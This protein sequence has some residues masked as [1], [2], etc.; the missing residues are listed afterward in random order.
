VARE[1]RGAGWRSRDG[2]GS[3]EPGPAGRVGVDQLRDLPNGCRHVPLIGPSPVIVVPHPRMARVR[4]RD[5]EDPR[6]WKDRSRILGYTSAWPRA[7]DALI[8]AIYQPCCPAPP[9]P[10]A[11]CPR[12]DRGPPAHPRHPPPARPGHPPPPPAT[13]RHG[14]DHP[15]STPPHPPDPGVHGTVRQPCGTTME[16]FN[17]TCGSSVVSFFRNENSKLVVGVSGNSRSN[18]AAIIQ[19]RYQEPVQ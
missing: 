10:L 7:A 13:A 12:G 14:H 11:N 16:Q 17:I 15:K 18:G 3:T 1:T 8:D 5:H 19:W 9:G 2:E 6:I 4:D